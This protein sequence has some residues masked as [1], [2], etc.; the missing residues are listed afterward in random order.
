MRFSFILLVWFA[1]SASVVIAIEPP[2]DAEARNAIDHKLAAFCQTAILRDRG[3][4][5]SPFAGWSD[6]WIFTKLVAEERFLAA[7]K[8]AKSPAWLRAPDTKIAEQKSSSCP[9]SRTEELYFSQSKSR[10]SEQLRSTLSEDLHEKLPMVYLRIEGAMALGRPEFT[11]LFEDVS[12]QSR[13]RKFVRTTSEEKS[14]VL[15]RTLFGLNHANIDVAPLY[16]AELRKVSADADLQIVLHM[17]TE[18][19]RDRLWEMLSGSKGLDAVVTAPPS[20]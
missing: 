5:C 20:L 12:T 8:E 7:L 1:A 16:Q 13:I 2:D 15:H 18:T 10:Y 11:P 3:L 9:N 14:L 19:E 6:D 4:A 17:L